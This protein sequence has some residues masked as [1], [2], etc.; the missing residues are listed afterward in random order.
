MS[1][2]N[3]FT[4]ISVTPPNK[5]GQLEMVINSKQINEIDYEIRD[6]DNNVYYSTKQQLND[7]INII[8]PSINKI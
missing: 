5:D 8:I 6:L 4:I 7:G 3:N 1:S 2:N